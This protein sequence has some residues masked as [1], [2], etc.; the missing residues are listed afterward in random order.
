VVEE[1]AFIKADSIIDVATMPVVVV[2]EE[3]L[4]LLSVAPIEEGAL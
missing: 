1:V 2:G 4:L 3:A